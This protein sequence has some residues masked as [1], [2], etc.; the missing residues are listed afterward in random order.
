[1]GVP[2]VIFADPRAGRPCY[3]LQACEIPEM[4]T[5]PSGD[6][7]FGTRMQFDAQTAAEPRLDTLDPAKI[8]QSAAG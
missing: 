1:M 6:F 5:S 4:L 8:G 2:P 7:D 3:R